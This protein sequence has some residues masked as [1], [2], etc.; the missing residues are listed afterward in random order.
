MEFLDQLI[1]AVLD[2]ERHGQRE[3][4]AR[5]L[6]DDAGGVRH[7]RHQSRV[8]AECVVASVRRI[9][10]FRMIFIELFS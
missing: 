2:L 1:R 7:R 9:K 5:Q 10:L 3:A 8:L 4:V 6:L